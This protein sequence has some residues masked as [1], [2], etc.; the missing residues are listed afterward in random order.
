MIRIAKT[1][2][3]ATQPLRTY[4]ILGRSVGVFRESGGGF[5]AM[6]MACKHQ[7]ADLSGGRLKDNIITCP[8]HGWKY[9]LSTG[10]CTWGAPVHLRPYAC[11]V[12]G[13]DIYISLRPVEVDE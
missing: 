9:D 1:S 6:E 8:W 3:F 12:R 11:E 5:R 2:D 4:R 7:G 10:E 13:E